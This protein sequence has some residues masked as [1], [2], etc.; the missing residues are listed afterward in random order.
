MADVFI[1]EITGAR[2][3]HNSEVAAW[4]IIRALVAGEVKPARLL[5]RCGR[6]YST[7]VLDGRCHKIICRLKNFEPFPKRA[8]P[9]MPG[10]PGHLACAEI[11]CGG[12]GETPKRVYLRGVKDLAQ[13]R[14]DLCLAVQAR[15]NEGVRRKRWKRLVLAEA[16]AS[17]QE[18]PRPEAAPA[19]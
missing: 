5:M 2:R 19:C 9:G 4:K 12:R 15:L 1:K 14:A 18:S 11:F 16:Q 13:C 6:I 17:A 3:P 10:F 7:V 8:L